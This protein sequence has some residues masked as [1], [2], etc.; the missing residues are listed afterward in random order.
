MLGLFDAAWD[1]LLPGM[2]RLLA[3]T[4]VQCVK[5]LFSLLKAFRTV[6]TDGSHPLS[7]A[8]GLFQWVVEDVLDQ[9]WNALRSQS[10]DEETQRTLGVLLDMI[11]IFGDSLF[12]GFGHVE[13]GSP[14]FRDFPLCLHRIL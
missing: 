7:V 4:D 10:Q 2:K 12:G 14:S 5:L 11:G 8:D 9:S 1:T 3:L 13:V 6:F